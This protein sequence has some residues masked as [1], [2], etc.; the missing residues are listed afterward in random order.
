MKGTR[1]LGENSRVIWNK[2]NLVF[3]K[4]KDTNSNYISRE[5]VLG[6]CRIYN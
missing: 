3:T 2:G 1:R 5:D 4:G 6:W